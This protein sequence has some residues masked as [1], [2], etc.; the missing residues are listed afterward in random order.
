MTWADIAD[1]AT[2]VERSRSEPELF[3]AIYDRHFRRAYRYVASRL[4]P[5]TAE[6]LAAE[7][8]L[9]AFSDRARGGDREVLLLVAVG[10]LSYEEVSQALS[11]PLGT[12]G[13]WFNRARTQVRKAFGGV[14]PLL[15]NSTND[16]K[17]EQT[18]DE[19]A[20]VSQ[21]LSATEPPPEAV[22]RGRERLAE[23]SV[24]P[25]SRAGVLNPHRGDAA[26]QFVGCESYLAAVHV[27]PG[28]GGTPVPWA[29]TVAAIRGEIAS[30]DW[31]VVGRGEID[32]HEAIESRWK[33]EV[34]PLYGPDSGTRELWVNAKA[35]LP[36]EEIL[37]ET[38]A[39]KQYAVTTYQFLPP[40]PANL[41]TFTVVIPPGFTRQP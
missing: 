28:E 16:D 23:F 14:N 39:R 36:V 32:G 10:G 17:P 2:V 30:G 6:D 13:S 25:R 8:F 19:I 22:T 38:G 34:G 3:A 40:T 27:P 26:T 4:G 20:L 1:D 5:D 21:L 15:D 9:A 7:A 37:N 18:M 12:V 29:Q 31:S 35:Y 11:I 33:N 24:R 41:A